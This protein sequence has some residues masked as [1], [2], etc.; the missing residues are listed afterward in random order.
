MQATNTTTRTY[1]CPACEGW[2]ER[3]FNRSS[4]RDPQCDE[5]AE[6]GQC[7]G[8]GVITAEAGEDMQ[9]WTGS[10]GLAIA[11]QRAAARQADPL[12]LLAGER[13][14]AIADHRRGWTTLSARWRY[15][16]LVRRAFVPVLAQLADAE[17]EIAFRL[18]NEANE[19]LRAAWA[20]IG[21]GAAA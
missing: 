20:R 12:V 15:T 14:R 9:P 18:Q 7:E 2:G 3:R 6:C 10:R 16:P 1:L 21:W 11:G 13:A 4:S 17:E 5:T 19:R 8:F